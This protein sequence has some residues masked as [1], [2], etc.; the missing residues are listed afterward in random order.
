MYIVQGILCRVYSAGYV[1]YSGQTHTHYIQRTPLAEFIPCACHHSICTQVIYNSSG[2]ATHI[3]AAGLLL[4]L[5]PLLALLPVPV[6]Q[7]KRLNLICRFIC[8]LICRFICHLICRFICHL[9]CRFICHLI[10]RF[11]CHLICRLICH[12]ICRLI[13]HLICRFICHVSLSV[14]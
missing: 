8:H 6:L 4:P 5:L 10:C 2:F 3:T 12:L 7:W 9:I 1:V 11:I 14:T 13:C